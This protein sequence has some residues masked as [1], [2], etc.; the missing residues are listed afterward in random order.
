MRLSSILLAAVAALVTVSDSSSTATFVEQT[1]T[2]QNKGNSNRLLRTH[3]T[4]DVN[5]ESEDQEEERGFLPERVAA[6]AALLKRT[7]VENVDDVLA[8]LK[9]DTID[10]LL[11]IYIKKNLEYFDDIAK[12][13]I[14]P[15]KLDDI[16]GIAQKVESKTPAQLRNDE[17]YQLSLAYKDYWKGIYGTV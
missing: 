17:F 7:K 3:T 9:D 12:Q 14:D 15:N 13:D 16:L 4:T 2:M 10:H 8:K 5:E 1:N 11:P 6:A